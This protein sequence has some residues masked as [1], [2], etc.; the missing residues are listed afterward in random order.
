[1]LKKQEDFWGKADDLLERIAGCTSA[2]VAFSGG[3]DSSFLAAAAKKVLA[4]RAVAV[5]AVSPT[6][7]AGERANA[8]AV[9][10]EIGIKHIEVESDE[11][12]VP[13]FAANN[14]NRCYYCKKYRL[15]DI[16]LWAEK[17]G[18]EWVL[19]GSNADDAHDWRP[20]I[21]A[22]EE[23]PRVKSPLKDSG[24]KKEEIRALAKDWGLSIWDK[25]ASPCL[26]SRIKYGVPVT[27]ER[28]RMIEAAERI[29]A[30]Y[31]PDR[32]NIR[33]RC[34]EDLARV[35]VDE[36]VLPILAGRPVAGEL[37]KRLA[38]VGFS[39]VT[40]DLTGFRSG[41]LNA[42]INKTAEVLL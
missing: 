7:S 2:A 37:A 6:L 32:T 17:N 36:A 3:A 22:L 4:D 1:M 38:A 31:C 29:V 24:L 18:Y 11:T 40:L 9:A 16:C 42:D 20:G 28:L 33:V 21:K 27:P 23:Y 12:S 35:E 34:H 8:H 41:S 19:E 30:E 15:R 14:A 39:F 10:E 13:E 5:T 25:P 26:A